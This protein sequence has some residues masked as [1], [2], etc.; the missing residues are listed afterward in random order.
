MSKI[1]AIF[2]QAG[3][4]MKT[5]LTM[6]LGYQLH[7]NQR[8]VLLVD[9][10]PQASLTTFMGL[11]PHELEAIVGGSILNEETQLPI[12]HNLHGMDL[13]PANITLSAVELQLASVMAREVRLHKALEPVLNQYDFILI[14]CPPSLGVLSILSLSAATHVL[15]PIQTHF[16]AFKGT[17]LLLD[18]IKQVKKHVNP[19]LAIAGIVPTLYSNASQDKV[20]LEALQQQLSSLAPVFDPI[21]RATAFAD[22]AMNRQPLAVYAPKHPAVAVLNKIAQGMEKL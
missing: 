13:I 10:D 8:K 18:T 14:D 12:H 7:L 22:A 1:I 9:I 3:G 16:K 17:E 6:N 5:S 15:I 2:N 11:E 21:G 19:K 4:V 20:I